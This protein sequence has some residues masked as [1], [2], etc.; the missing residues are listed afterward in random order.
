MENTKPE[1]SSSLNGKKDQLQEI[2]KHKLEGVML[3]SL[4]RYEDLGEK[5]TSYFLNLEKRIFTDKVITKMI[6]EDKEYTST[7]E[8]LNSQIMYFKTLFSE[9]IDIDDA[10]SLEGK[11]NI[12]N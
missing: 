1:K 2:R 8:I 6:E 4:C 10:N 12:Q 3:R 9:N 7:E 5:P 11:L